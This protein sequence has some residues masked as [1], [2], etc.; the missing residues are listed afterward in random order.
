MSIFKAYDV[1]G[2]IPDEIN[3]DLARQ[4]GRAYAAFV[5]PQQV[6]VGRDIRLTSATLADALI[7]G[8]VGTKVGG[9]RQISVPGASAFG[10][11]GDSG[12][13]LPAGTDVVLVADLLAVY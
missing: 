9:R 3:E 11:K 1:R 10:G 6:I 2:R 4:I 12:L 13:G 7:E 5:R 8:L